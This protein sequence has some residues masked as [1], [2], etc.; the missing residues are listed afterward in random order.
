MPPREGAQTDDGMNPSIHHDALEPNL[1]NSDMTILRAL[2]P[3]N[4]PWEP[5]YTRDHPINIW[6]LGERLNTLDL[7]D[8]HRTLNGLEHLDLAYECPARRAAG[9]VW[10]QRWMRTDKGDKAVTT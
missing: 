5:D 3:W 2:P 1:T 8:L 10:P 6:Q 9:R 4:S 7:A